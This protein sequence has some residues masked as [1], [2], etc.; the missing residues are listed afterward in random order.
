M[1]LFQEKRLSALV[2]GGTRG[3]GR[4]VSV[5]LARVC[6]STV[7]VNYLENHQAAEETS[8]LI[9]KAGAR[10]VLIPANLM[11]PAEIQSMF[12]QLQSELERVDI[13]V[14]C[15]AIGSFKPTLETKANQWDLSMNVNARSFLL[16]VQRVVPLMPEGSIVSISS[17]GS[18]RAVPNYSVIGVS[19]AALEALI[20]Y[21]AAELAPKGI[22]VNGVSG[23]FIESESARKFPDSERLLTSVCERTPAGRLGQPEDIADVVMLLVSP[24]ARWIYGQ[25]IVADGGLSLL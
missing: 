20:R 25:V 17:L 22:R 19:K 1:S 5:T 23:G 6:A 11:H 4:A 18:Q 14:H 16:C 15:A 2:T 13:F 9:E 7:V 21:L 24:A 10:P 12:H 3:I 8:S